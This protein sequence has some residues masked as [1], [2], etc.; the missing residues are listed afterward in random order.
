M[1]IQASLETS[2]AGW[3]HAGVVNIEASWDVTLL[4]CDQFLKL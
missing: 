3:R 1:V 4:S 2:Y